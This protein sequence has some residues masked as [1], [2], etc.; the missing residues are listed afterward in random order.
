MCQAVELH[1][2]GKSVK[3]I[4]FELDL[5]EGRIYQIFR[6]HNYELP[7]YN[8]NKGV[9]RLWTD[10]EVE[11]LKANLDKPASELAKHLNRTY[12]AVLSKLG[13][14]DLHTHYHCIV[15]NTEISQ[16]GMYCSEHNWIART[17]TSTKNHCKKKGREFSLITERAIELLLGDCTYCGQSGGGIDRVDSSK[18]YVEGNVVSC[19]TTCNVMKMDTPKDKWIAQMKLILENL[20]ER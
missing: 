5:T 6:Q 2:Q 8:P 13:K 9:K 14:L 4:A 1:K 16:K 19:C 15:C 7:K 10:E 3:D 18:G 17:L 12:T 20:N 11:Y